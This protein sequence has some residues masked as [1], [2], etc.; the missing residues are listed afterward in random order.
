MSVLFL[1]KHEV[2]EDTAKTERDRCASGPD[3]LPQKVLCRKAYD[4]GRQLSRF[5]KSLGI[6]LT[7]GMEI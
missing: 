6:I 3:R 4:A 7:N 5:V 2:P 1:K